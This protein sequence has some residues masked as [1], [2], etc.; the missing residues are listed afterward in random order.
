MSKNLVWDHI[1]TVSPNESLE[2]TSNHL[3]KVLQEIREGIW[4]EV[5]IKTSDY[6]PN[7]NI[8]GYRRE[9]EAERKNRLKQAAR[10]R[11]AAKKQKEEREASELAQYERLKKK[12]EKKP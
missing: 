4:T 10:A 1:V 8:Y 12:F 9:T 5:R 11:E 6:D 7:W 2:A 3:L